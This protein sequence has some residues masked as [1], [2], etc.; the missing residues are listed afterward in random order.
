MVSNSSVS[1]SRS[2]YGEAGALNDSAAGFIESGTRMRGG[3][4][5]EMAA[6]LGY[7][8][9]VMITAVRGRLPLPVLVLFVSGRPLIHS[10][11]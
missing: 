8:P 1:I 3:G 5:A 4:R 6:R 11:G 9:I 2:A 10:L 7:Y